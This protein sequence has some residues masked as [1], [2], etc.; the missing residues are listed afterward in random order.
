MKGIH[1]SWV[2]LTLA[3]SIVLLSQPAYAKFL[4]PTQLIDACKAAAAGR[5]AAS[6]FTSK[7][8]TLKD[9]Y[10]INVL[11][12][13]KK[14]TL[15]IA[16]LLH[17]KGA[18]GGP[19]VPTI[20]TICLDGQQDT[21]SNDG[22]IVFTGHWFKRSRML[23]RLVNFNHLKWQAIPRQSLGMVETKD[24]SSTLKPTQG[25]LPDCLSPSSITEENSRRD[26]KF[27]LCSN[28]TFKDRYFTYSLFL[29]DGTS[30]PVVLDPQIIHHPN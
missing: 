14:R 13:K 30:N 25:Q 17:N 2:G 21:T 12:L 4:P 15:S 22:N 5:D 11:Q 19:E 1:A 26:L 23:F 28:Y 9:G 27:P 18:P 24:I 7:P 6:I 16:V 10:T 20:D 3:A 29:D 8:L